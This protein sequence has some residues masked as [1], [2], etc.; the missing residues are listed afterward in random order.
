MPT[1]K[2]NDRIIGDDHPTFIIAEIGVN[3]NG[4]LDYAFQLIDAAVRAGADAVKFQKRNL[5]KLYPQKYLDN[6]NV[7]EKN[8]N[9]LL[10]I[11]KRVELS[12]DD[13]FKIVEYCRE[14]EVIFMCSAFDDDSADF[15]RSFGG[16]SVQG[17]LSGYD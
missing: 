2:I 11:L 6:A 14:K 5:K 15:V 17:R 9:Y 1:I 3:H 16:A 13:Y 4:I 10:P 12:D 7:G 8:L